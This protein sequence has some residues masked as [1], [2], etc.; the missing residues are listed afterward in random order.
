MFTSF[1]VNC[2]LVEISINPLFAVY[3]G[4]LFFLI[5]A[6]LYW[7]VETGTHPQPKLLASF[8]ALI[9]LS[10]FICLILDTSL[11]MSMS[12]LVKIPLYTILGASVCFALL[13]SIIDI[14][15]Y[16]SGMCCD[17]D[18]NQAIIQSENQVYLVVGTSLVMG[19]LFGFIFGWLDVEDA[20]FYHL[21]VALMREESVCYPIGAVVGGLG[22]A[23]NQWLR[24]SQQ[25]EYKFDPIR[26]DDLDEQFNL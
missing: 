3:F 21:R 18:D 26:D 9:A 16:F 19:G 23:A 24:E 8:A 11:I 2:S 7:R 20:S 13:F 25:K 10:G 14:M 6:V 1:T 5:A 15:N 4:V 17:S 22:A 12:N